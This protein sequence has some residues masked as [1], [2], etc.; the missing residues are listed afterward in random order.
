M[1]LSCLW[2]LCN[3]IELVTLRRTQTICGTYLQSLQFR[4]HNKWT[5]IAYYEI[6][7]PWSINEFSCKNFTYFLLPTFYLDS[8]CLSNET[9]INEFG[10]QFTRVTHKKILT[11]LL[12]NIPRVLAHESQYQ[13]PIPLKWN[14]KRSNW[15][16]FIRFKCRK[17]LRPFISN[18][19]MALATDQVTPL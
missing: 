4:S 6:R 18:T 10:L 5:G 8:F 7:L 17:H 9:R 11:Q 14:Q 15:M 19:P 3:N 13:L 12:P 2:G 16:Y 1:S